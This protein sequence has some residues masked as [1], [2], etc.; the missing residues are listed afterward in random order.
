[1]SR[2]SAL[3]TYRQAL[4]ELSD[5]GRLRHTLFEARGR[6]VPVGAGGSRLRRG[7]SAEHEAPEAAAAAHLKPSRALY[8]VV[9]TAEASKVPAA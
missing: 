9:E 5:Q 8:F 2:S 4:R 6:G 3:G 7:N 1:V